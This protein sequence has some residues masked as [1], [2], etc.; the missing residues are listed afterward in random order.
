MKIRCVCGMI[1][2]GEGVFMKEDKYLSKSYTDRVKGIC[3]IMVVLHHLYLYGGLFAGTPVGTLL[4]LSGALAVS[5]FFFYSGYGLMLSS[6]KEGYIR[7]FFRSRFLPLYC[8]YVVCVLLYSLWTLWLEGT[9]P[10]GKLV[11]SFFFGDTIVANGWYLQAT[12][13]IYLIYLFSFSAFRTAKARILSVSVAVFVYSAICRFAGLGDWWYQT[14]P[15]FV[16]GMV[17]HTRKAQIDR[18]LKKCAWIIFIAGGLL[19]LIIST[20]VS[21]LHVDPLFNW[22]HFVFFVCAVISFSYILSGTP[23]IDNA[24]FALCGRY[25]LE[26]YVSHGLFVMLINYVF[27]GNTAIYVSTV[28]AGTVILS[29]I[30]KM[31]YTRAI[32]CLFRAKRSR[33]V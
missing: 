2:P 12:F 23:I 19:Y 8:F 11:L 24:F 10:L 31:I 32:P 20:A 30:L 18:L 21:I 7:G 15:C 33:P 25:S 22:I 13:V 5:V 1:V 4:G 29:V 14:V 26:S 9:V 27:F 3:A 6:Q 17:Y 16:F 28:I